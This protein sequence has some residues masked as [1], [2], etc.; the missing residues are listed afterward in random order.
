[1]KAL[2]RIREQA[3][4]SIAAVSSLLGISRQALSQME[5]RGDIKLS[6]LKK[7]LALYG[8]EI[9]LVSKKK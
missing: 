2:K 5:S 1:M 7:M 6:T 3:G 8:I 4:F 9:A